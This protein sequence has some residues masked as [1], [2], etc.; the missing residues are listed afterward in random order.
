LAARSDHARILQL[1]QAEG[2]LDRG[3]FDSRNSRPQHDPILPSVRR[4]NGATIRH[5]ARRRRGAAAFLLVLEKRRI[6]GTWPKRFHCHACAESSLGCNLWHGDS[7]DQYTGVVAGQ[8]VTVEVRAPGSTTV[9]DTYTATLDL[10]GK[11]AVPTTRIGTFDVAIK[12]AHWLKHAIR[13]V[14]LGPTGAS[15]L[16]FT[17]RNGDVNRDNA[18]TLGDFAALRAAYG[19]SSGDANW[20]ADADLNGDDAVTLGDFA[21]LRASYGISGD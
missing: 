15:G 16:D 18:V 19:T 3:Q 21:I 9:L 13:N 7:L 12:T 1:L 17:L 8:T 2:R 14:G 6:P 20:N 11:F 4:G 5:R 10:D